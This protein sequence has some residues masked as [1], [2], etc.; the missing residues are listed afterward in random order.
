MERVAGSQ[1]VCPRS[2]VETQT[3]RVA[4]LVDVAI[5]DRFARI[6]SQAKAS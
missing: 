5:S 3:Y 2:L 6:G 4:R 1:T